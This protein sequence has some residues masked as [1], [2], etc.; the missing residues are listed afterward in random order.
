MSEIVDNL[1]RAPMVM[2]QTNPYLN[3]ASMVYVDIADIRA[4]IARIEELEA[5]VAA[6]EMYLDR[7]AR[8]SATGIPLTRKATP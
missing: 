3:V 5:Q 7:N 6:F 4:A 1:R 8:L 2:M